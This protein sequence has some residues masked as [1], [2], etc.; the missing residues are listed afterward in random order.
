MSLLN[1]KA[2]KTLNI[3]PQKKLWEPINRFRRSDIQRNTTRSR[4]DLSGEI[5]RLALNRI[6]SSDKGKK[7]ISKRK[8]E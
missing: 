4:N 6:N 7:K 5:L 3:W 8:I 2:K 1:F